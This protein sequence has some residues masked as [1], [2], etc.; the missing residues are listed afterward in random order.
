MRLPSESNL[1]FWYQRSDLDRVRSY[2]DLWGGLGRLRYDF[3]PQD[4][5]FFYARYEK[6]DLDFVDSLT[7]TFSVNSQADGSVRQGLQSTDPIVDDHVSVKALGYSFQ[8]TA[9]LGAVMLSY[10]AEK[11]TTST[12]AP[13]DSIS[14]LGQPDR[15]EA[16]P[17]SGRLALYHVWPICPGFGRPRAPKTARRPRGPS[18]PG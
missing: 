18:Y 7:G 13:A 10:L 2:K 14:T 5:Q 6:L 17:L 15:P 1:T 8:G 3:T 12:S 9:H 11:S 16:C 4:L